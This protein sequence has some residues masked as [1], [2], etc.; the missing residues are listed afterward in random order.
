M[1]KHISTSTELSQGV[2]DIHTAKHLH[3]EPLR[4]T[5]QLQRGWC[6]EVWAN[7]LCNLGINFDGPKQRSEERRDETRRSLPYLLFLSVEKSTL[8]FTKRVKIIQS[9]ALNIYTPLSIK[10]Q[11]D[12]MVFKLHVPMPCS[13]HER[14]A[15][16]QT[17]SLCFNS[18]TSFP[19]WEKKNSLPVFNFY[20]YFKDNI[21]NCHTYIKSL[22]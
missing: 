9:L 16:E 21:I 15:K 17:V 2:R 18:V 22:P 1:G 4:I 20:Q 3:E 7:T 13:V 12:I 5:L 8:I 6:N 14:G 11:V 10:R 19:F